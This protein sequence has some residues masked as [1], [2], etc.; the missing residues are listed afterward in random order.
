[1]IRCVAQPDCPATVFC[2]YLPLLLRPYGYS[3]ICGERNSTPHLCRDCGLRCPRL[4][5]YCGIAHPHLVPLFPCPPSSPLAVSLCSLIV[6]GYT[7]LACMEAS[8]SYSPPPLPATEFS[9]PQ[10]LRGGDLFDTQHVTSTILA[11]WRTF[12]PPPEGGRWSHVV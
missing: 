7:P 2:H 9:A 10:A 5:E 11:P 1:M 12:Y 8:P 3:C 6:Y 4:L